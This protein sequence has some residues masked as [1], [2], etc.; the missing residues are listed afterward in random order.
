MTRRRSS[1]AIGR[2]GGVIAAVVALAALALSLAAVGSGA[3]A[4]EPGMA[5]KTVKIGFVGD[6]FPSST[7]IPFQFRNGDLLPTAKAV[8]DY[9]NKNG[10][11]G[12]RQIELDAIQ[13]NSLA[14]PNSPQ[15]ACLKMTKDDHVWLVIGQYM[16]AS[17]ATCYQKNK[18][19]LIDAVG[20]TDATNKSLYPYH[21]STAPSFSAS[22]KDWVYGAKALGL[23]SPKQGFKKLGLISISA[24]ADIWDSPKD[25][26]KHWLQTAGVKNYVEFRSDVTTQALT[27]SHQPA[28]LKMRQGNVTTMMIGAQPIDRNFTALGQ[29]QS[30]R[31][32]YVWGDF[33]Y[34]TLL[35]NTS[36][37]NKDAIDKSY[38]VTAYRED[39]KAPMTVKCNGILK[40]AGIGAMSD[41]N[42]D[43]LMLETCEYF[44]LVKAV[45][46]KDPKGSATHLGFA[47]A[48]GR[49]G[50]SFK[51]GNEWGV[52]FYPGRTTPVAQIIFNQ[53]DKSCSCWHKIKG[54]MPSYFNPTTD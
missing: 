52:T 1:R 11:A 18:T 21:I 12:G 54:P 26:I 19:I 28:L 30:Y 15:T 13:I 2:R 27:T 10:G 49:L 17:G 7:F 33:H 42:K 22:A 5:A 6:N 45:M 41:G 37:L 9:I 29:Q 51:T 31:P 34:A 44:L 25:G 50:S 24:E 32:K 35:A 47:K 16:V 39:Y 36:F 48:L 4:A 40:G 53:F 38:G 3:T 8:V 14:D 20:Q 43:L 23:F 46:D